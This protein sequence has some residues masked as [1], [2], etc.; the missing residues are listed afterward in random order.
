MRA[1]SR[2][3]HSG[4]RA[5]H[6]RLEAVVRSHIE[7]RWRAPLHQPTRIAFERLTALLRE[8]ELANIVLDSG[9]G[10]GASTRRLAAAHPGRVVIGVD[11]SRARLRKSG[12]AGF[13]RREANCLWVRAELASF[14]RLALAA[15]WKLRHHYLLYPNP[16]PKPAHLRR[17][18][19]GHPVF[20]HLLALGGRLELRSNWRVYAEEFAAACS[21]A[22]GTDV[23]PRLLKPEVPVSPFEAKYL[24][25]GHALWSVVVNPEK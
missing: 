22:T 4:Q 11:K 25:S 9:C 24:A 16:W 17:R 5:V 19:H 1:S 21:L 13:P 18:W 10:T 3:V 14:W 6:E 20:P 2:T 7:G 8:D 23:R 15:G 12:V